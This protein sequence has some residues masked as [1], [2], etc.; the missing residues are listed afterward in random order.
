MVATVTVVGFLAVF[1]AAYYLMGSHGSSTKDAGTAQKST[2]PLA[3]DLEVVGVRIVSQG[4]G[5]A[6]RF[7]LVN[8]SGVELTDVSGSVTLW[9]STSHS[10]EDKV[11][12]FNFHADSIKPVEFNELTAPLTT[13]KQAS[14]MP[15]W[16]NITADVQITAP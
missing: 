11:G 14:D 4:Q 7:I 12:T 1:G 3:K 9:A 5:Q 10:D 16:R 6:A 13:D 8:H 2:N 15:D